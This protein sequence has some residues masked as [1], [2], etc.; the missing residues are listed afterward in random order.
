MRWFGRHR[1]Q[2]ELDG[3]QD[4]V[5]RLPG[6]RFRAVLEVAGVPF[7]LMSET[8]QRVVLANFGTFLNSLSFPVQTLVRVLPVDIDGYLGR[9]EGRARQDLPERLA[10]LALDHVAFVRTMAR[11]RN[12]LERHFY[13][14]VPAQ[15]P[16]FMGLLA[17]LRRSQTDAVL[18]AEV[19]RKQLA[20]RCEEMS[21]QLQRCGLGVRRLDDVELAEL[22]YA[23]W[24]PE[25]SRL[26]R[27]RRDLGGYTSL[28]VRA[29]GSA[30]KPLPRSRRGE[31]ACA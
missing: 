18:Q 15:D 14:V 17:L 13:I 26:Q 28:V 12:L 10:E 31:P 30:V 3:I 5:V 25:L 7:G 2:L 22:L 27:L 23:C 4:G 1:V 29:A 16:K 24:C 8:E 19:A 9:I 20:F 6:D 11:S 21:R